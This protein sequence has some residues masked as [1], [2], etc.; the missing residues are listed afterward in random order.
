VAIIGPPNA[1]NQRCSITLVGQ[2]IRHRHIQ[3]ANHTKPHS[4]IVTQK[5]GQNC[6]HRHARL[7]DRTRA[8]RQM[9]H[10]VAAA[11]WRASTFC[12][13]SVTHSRLSPHRLNVDRESQTLSRQNNSC[14]GIVDAVPKPK[15][16]PLIERF[17]Q[18]FDLRR[19][20]AAFR[21]S[22]AP[23]AMAC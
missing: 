7:H 3:A 11:G 17:R 4:S 13:C 5:R 21:A 1:G 20:S 23:D 8:W 19:N 15:L 18:E 14:I 22:R 12:C 2:K 16:L 9:M 6:I 10:E